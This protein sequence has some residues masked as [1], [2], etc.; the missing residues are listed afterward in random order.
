MASDFGILSI[1]RRDT[2]SLVCVLA[3]RAS[4]KRITQKSRRILTLR[5]LNVLRLR[6]RSG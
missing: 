6:F 4:L 1:L 3:V 2:N 5:H